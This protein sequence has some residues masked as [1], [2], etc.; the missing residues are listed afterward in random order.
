MKQ[1]IS[2]KNWG[3]YFTPLKIVKAI[4]DMTDIKEGENVCDPACGVG[5]FL[6]EPLISKLDRVYEIKNKEIKSKIKIVGYDK[7]FDTEEQK[8]IILAKANMLIY[9]S[10]LLKRY[11]NL[12]KEFSDLFNSSFVLKT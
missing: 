1:S 11:P 7:G 12:T 9:L 4:V 8:T 3:Q 2:K 6:L 10:D 5:K